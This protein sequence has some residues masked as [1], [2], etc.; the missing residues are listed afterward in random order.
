[1]NLLEDFGEVAV[2]K[3]R[4]EKEIARVKKA[5]EA[6]LKLKKKYGKNAVVKGMNLEEGATTIQRNA[7]IGGH[8]A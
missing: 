8:K 2:E 1:M 4:H 3:E 7:Q 6:I 5:Q